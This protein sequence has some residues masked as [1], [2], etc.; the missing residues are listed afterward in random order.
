MGDMGCFD[1]FVLLL[2]LFIQETNKRL[3]IP[4]LS[5]LRKYHHRDWLRSHDFPEQ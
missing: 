2:R 3:S 5:T 1:I 4:Y